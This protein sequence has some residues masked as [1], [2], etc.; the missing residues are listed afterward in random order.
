MVKTQGRARCEADID[1]SAGIVNAACIGMK[2]EVSAVVEI[3]TAYGLFSSNVMT[4]PAIKNIPD[5]LFGK[6][7]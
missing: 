1:L 5:L 2:D 6:G 4:E 7:E 3:M